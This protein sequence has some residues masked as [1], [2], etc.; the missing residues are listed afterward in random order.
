[1]N[2]YLRQYKAYEALAARYRQHSAA[3]ED[4]YDG[5]AR[6]VTEALG[7]PLPPGTPPLEAVQEL[8]KELRSVRRWA[9]QVELLMGLAQP[10]IEV[11]EDDGQV[12]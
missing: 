8:A 5:I 6:V 4:L 10:R 1:M 9:R 3:A 2:Q 11:I 12:E 7:R